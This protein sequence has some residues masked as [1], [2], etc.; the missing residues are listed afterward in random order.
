MRYD[1]GMTLDAA[2][3]VSLALGILVVLNLFVGMGIRTFYPAP[4]FADACPPDTAEIG[5]RSACEAA[6]GRWITSEREAMESRVPA[7]VVE[8]GGFEPYCDEQ[9]ECRRAFE[10]RM[11]AYRR[12]VFV[13][14][15]V[16]GF[17]AL[18]AGQLIG[19]SSAVS[20]GLTFGGVVS[21]VVGAVGYW[22]DMDEIVR[23]VLL[24]IVLAV[25]VW[26]GYRKTRSES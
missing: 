8:R 6:G 5:T 25:L 11:E 24:G 15:I 14:W 19:A 22:S 3:T 13:V 4:E 17:A 9:F 10:D 21:F 7:P 12:N 23:F 20:S 18:L 2:K 16:A 1:R 26:L